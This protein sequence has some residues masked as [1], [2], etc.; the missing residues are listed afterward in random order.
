VLSFVTVTSSSSRRRAVVLVPALVLGVLI[1]LMI[2]TRAPAQAP[3]S[4]CDGS[5]AA[6]LLGLPARDWQVA[7]WRVPDGREVIAAVPLPPLVPTS[8]TKVGKPNKGKAPETAPLVV[9][10]GVA[11]EQTILWRGD[12]RP[13]AKETPELREALERS[14]EWLVGVE[15]QPLG[16]ERGVRVGVVGHWGGDVMT[17][18]EIALLFRLPAEGAPRLLWSGLGNSRESRFDY[19]RIENIATFQLVDERTIEKTVHASHNINRDLA[20]P[21]PRARAKELEKKCVSTP[22]EPRRL[23]VIKQ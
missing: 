16:A 14:E 18:R 22:Q 9:R 1:P 20:T 4:R 5:Q 17:V 21:L 19:C 13:E 12:V 7:C 8:L 6:R 10:L 2:G 23:P 11:R 15:D 3:T